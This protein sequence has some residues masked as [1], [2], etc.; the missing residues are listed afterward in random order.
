[1]KY[2]IKIKEFLSCR[3]TKEHKA[4]SRLVRKNITIKTV[5]IRNES[6]N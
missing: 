2:E 4:R 6:L 1:M 5:A 3:S